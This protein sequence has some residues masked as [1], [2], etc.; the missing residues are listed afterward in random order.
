[1]NPVYV[2]AKAVV[3]HKLHL[4]TLSGLERFLLSAVMLPDRVATL[5]A[6]TNVEPDLIDPKYDYELL[7][8]SPEANL[9]LFG[10]V[11]ER[12]HADTLVVPV[13]MGTL[14][15]GAAE[16]GTKFKIE[17]RRVPYPV[18]FPIHSMEDVRKLEPP[19][20]IEGYQKMYFDINL[21]A[22][23]RY[24]NTLIFPV[25]DGPWD[26]GMLLRGDKQL[27]LDLRIHK[28]YTRAKDPEKRERIRRYG[29]PDLYPALMDLTTRIAIRHIELAVKG[30]LSLLGTMLIDQ[31]ASKPVLSRED[32]F[33]FV[34]P[35]RLRVWEATG[36]KLGISYNCPSP[37]EIEL[38]M[39]DPVLLKAQG[40]LSNY[41]FPQTPEGI[42]LPEYDRPMLEM[43]LKYK[44]SYNYIVHGKFLRDA[45][46]AELEALIQRVCGLAT[47]MRA[48]MSVMLSSV[49]PG[50]S[51]D[52]ANLVFKLVE[53]YG[54]Y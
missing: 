24:P 39:Q 44:Q 52:K 21:A 15:T 50:A 35:Y 3:K 23:K 2:M 1:M 11:I 25:F 41:I 46:E 53:K 33:E 20:K 16:L 48:R 27:P 13:W 49:P 31:F 42:T 8:S 19:K 6:A 22:Q 45:N 28:D 51:V 4:G 54:R 43:A 36:K 17:K 10:K 7:A 26:L 9:E 18:E 29:D 34:H 37:A 40:S 12:V 38:N 5:L 47:Q 32:Y 14:T 30:G